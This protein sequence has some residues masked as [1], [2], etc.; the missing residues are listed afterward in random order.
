M[1]DESGP[2]RRA[3]NGIASGATATLLIDGVGSTSRTHWTLP[4]DD[5]LVRGFSYAGYGKLR[6]SSGHTAQPLRTTGDLLAEYFH[7]ARLAGVT[8]HPGAF[9]MGGAYLLAAIDHFGVSESLTVAPRILLVAPPLWHTQTSLSA[10]E[11][12]YARHMHARDRGVSGL[13]WAA[14]EILAPHLGQLQATLSAYLG[15]G[16][17]VTCLDWADDRISPPAPR[18]F[19]PREWIRRGI[20]PQNPGV[21]LGLLD[22][23]ADHAQL[24]GHPTVDV[25]L[26]L[27]PRPG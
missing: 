7:A 19:G 22:W 18:T 6:Y 9:S 8:L 11:A 16:G 12:E 26:G 15:E 27:V 2:S 1:A 10:I 13:L 24:R 20:D 17:V 25:A 5:R 3:L 23:F 21:G 4:F 14:K